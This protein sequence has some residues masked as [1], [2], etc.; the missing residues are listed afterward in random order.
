MFMWGAILLIT[1]II[2]AGMFPAQKY[3]YEWKDCLGVIPIIIGFAMCV[4]SLLIW[5]F[6]NL[7]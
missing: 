1:G 4:I 3:G 6:R 5:A 7:P 2:G